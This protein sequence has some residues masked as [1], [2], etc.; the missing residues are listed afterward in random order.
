MSCLVMSPC[1]RAAFHTVSRAA[2]INSQDLA[3][4]D[5]LRHWRAKSFSISAPYSAR[6]DFGY[7]RSSAR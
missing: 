7:N 6:N 2:P 3:P 1:T 5:A 4:A